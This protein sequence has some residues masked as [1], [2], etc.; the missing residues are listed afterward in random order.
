MNQALKFIIFQRIQSYK[1]EYLDHIF[2]ISFLLGWAQW[3]T[4]GDNSQGL[5]LGMDEG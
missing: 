2:L 3:V 4:P 1:L 5:G